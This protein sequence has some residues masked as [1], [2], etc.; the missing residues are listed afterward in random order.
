VKG[1]RNDRPKLADALC[2]MHK[3]ILVVAKLHRLAR[4]VHFVS[5]LMESGA[6]FVAVDFPRANRLTVHIIAAVAE[7]EAAMI[8]ARTKAEL[9]PIVDNVQASTGTGS[10]ASVSTA[11][12]PIHAPWDVRMAKA[13][14]DVMNG[15]PW[16]LY[17]LQEDWS[18]ED[19]N[20]RSGRALRPYPHPQFTRRLACALSLLSSSCPSR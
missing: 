14:G 8:S 16:E 11:A 7:H 4:S 15:F 17:N 20:G 19:W 10:L 2:R 18:Q 9:A 5:S 13:P 6:E 1:K 3:A 12:Q